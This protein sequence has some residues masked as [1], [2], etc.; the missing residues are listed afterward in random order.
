MKKYLIV[1]AA[2]VIALASCGD[3]KA[4]YTSIKFKSNEIMLAVGGS[5][6]LQVLYEPT[7]LDAPT[8][9]WAS[10]NAAVATVDETGTVTGVALGEANITAKVGELSA[11][12]K[13]SVVD[14]YDMI[15]WGG[16]TLWNLDKETI[17]SKDT[18]I[19]TLSSGQQ[20]KCV[21][22]PA[23][24]RVW[25]SDITFDDTEG[26]LSG[27]GLCINAEG[28]ALL[29]TDD[30]GKG[31]NYYYLGL[32]T[33]YFV[34]PAKYNPTDTTFAGCCPAGKITGTAE[35]HFAW[36]NDESGTAP[37]AFTGTFISAVDWDNQK[38]LSYMEGF[39]GV[40]VFAGDYNEAY[41]KF[42]ASWFQGDQAYGLL[43]VQNAEGEWEPKQP[44]EWAPLKE[45]YYEYLPEEAPKYT[46]KEYRAP[47]QD[48]S[49]FARPKDVFS[50]E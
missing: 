43:F 29:I 20:V 13:V 9:E 19:R 17:L 44:Y 41:Y 22:I 50:H 37:Q 24:Y 25:D 8:C 40:G 16:W 34:D 3:K 33:L 5:T 42:N 27:A 39:A 7:T 15:E 38:Y 11:V 32:S 1:L 26:S 12:C 6:K 2:A 21:M 45:Y 18:V 49:T 30:L 10:S 35:Q 28:T 36:L 4:P 23:T 31:P 14:P 47:K 46:V 48:L